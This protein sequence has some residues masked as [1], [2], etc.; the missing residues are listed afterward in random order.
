MYLDRHAGNFRSYVDSLSVPGIII[1]L[2]NMNKVIH[3][4]KLAPFAKALGSINYKL[5][6]IKRERALMPKSL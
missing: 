6:F 4:D 2:G 5:F 1:C 3:R